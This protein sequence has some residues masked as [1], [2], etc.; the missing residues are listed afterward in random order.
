MFNLLDD[1]QTAS[2]ILTQVET[3]MVLSNYLGAESVRLILLSTDIYFSKLQSRNLA[4]KL[5]NHFLIWII[6]I[7]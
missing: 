6:Q 2:S 4:L 1:Q 3:H 5:P 7:F